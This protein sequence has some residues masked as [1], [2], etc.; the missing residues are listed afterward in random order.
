MHPNTL[1]S[2]FATIFSVDLFER[3]CHTSTNQHSMN[4][5]NSKWG[6]IAYAHGVMAAFL[7][8]CDKQVPFS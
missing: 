6:A 5:I 2:H 4:S 8:M 1:K 3:T 7:C